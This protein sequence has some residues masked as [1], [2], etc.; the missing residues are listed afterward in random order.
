MKAYQLSALMGRLWWTG[1]MEMTEEQLLKH[2]K[3]PDSGYIY[4]TIEPKLSTV[5]VMPMTEKKGDL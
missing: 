1:S 5:M 2:Q 3:C 4:T